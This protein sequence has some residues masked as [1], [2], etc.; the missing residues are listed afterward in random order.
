M[1]AVRTSGPGPASAA[2]VCGGCGLADRCAAAAAP[3]RGP[4]VGLSLVLASLLHFLMPAAVALAGAAIAGSDP[5]RQ[6]CGGLIGLLLGMLVGTTVA[7]RYAATRARES[8]F[9]PR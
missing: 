9:E 7:R 8:C 6:L 1:Q 4:L 5:L 3:H 2:S